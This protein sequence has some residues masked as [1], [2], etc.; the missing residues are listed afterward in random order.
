MTE[1][2]IRI[3]EAGIC[4][5][6]GESHIPE[7]QMCIAEGAIRL[8]DNGIWIPLSLQDIPLIIFSSTE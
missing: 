2:E 6:E 8:R 5:K 1:V 7:S 3:P 4:I